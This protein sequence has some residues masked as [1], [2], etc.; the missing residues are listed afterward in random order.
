MPHCHTLSLN[1]DLTVELIDRLSG[2]RF[3]QIR[4]LEIQSSTTLTRYVLEGI[5]H[6]FP[7]VKRLRISFINSNM[8]MIRL[9]DGFKYLSNASFTIQ[10]N[11]TESERQWFRNPELSIRRVRRLKNGTFTCQ[12]TRLSLDNS[13][14]SV[15]VSINEQVSHLM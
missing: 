15:H 11:F 10:S 13:S 8:D 4:S 12:C 1:I 3:K 5:L 14:C 6:L 7:R 2:N 9:I